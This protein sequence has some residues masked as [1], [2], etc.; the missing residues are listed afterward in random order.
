MLADERRNG[1]LEG[2]ISQAGVRDRVV[3]EIGTGVAPLAL[4]C[5][6][7]GAAHVIACEADQELAALAKEIVLEN[8]FSEKI[9]VLP[10][11]SAEVIRKNLHLYNG[12]SPQIILTETLDCGVIGEGFYKI[13]SDIRRIARSGTRVLPSKVDQFGYLVQSSEAWRQAAV[14]P[15]VPGFSL[16]QGTFMRLNKLSR[17]YIAVRPESVQVQP[18]SS[19]VSIRSYDYLDAH[20]S[21]FVAHAEAQVEMSGTCHGLMTYFE[22]HFG[23]NIVITNRDGFHR[24]RH[25][26]LAFHPLGT[27]LQL[28]KGDTVLIHLRPDGRVTI[29]RY[30]DN[31]ATSSAV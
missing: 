30:D 22:A 16:P 15:E 12:T 8:R 5:A 29:R 4:L 28:A 1:L 25:W 6:S 23:K 10:F 14:D 24:C 27:P 26:A 17:P 7:Y 3:F 19:V 9:T 21:E 11:T 13:G 2:A 31:A 18:L 20:A